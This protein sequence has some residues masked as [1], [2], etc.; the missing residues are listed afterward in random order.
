MGLKHN[1][2][3]HQSLLS[4]FSF[5]AGRF[6]TSFVEERFSMETYEH[7]PDETQVEAAAILATL[8]AHRQRQLAG[9]VVAR[10]ERDTS[11]WKWISRWERVHR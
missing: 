1:V 8:Y 10:N 9:Q 5:I 4:S 6:D 11:N 3:F 2:P 7:A